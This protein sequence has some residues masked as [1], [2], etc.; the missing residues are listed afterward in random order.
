MRLLEQIFDKNVY[1]TI[2]PPINIQ[3][4]C[5]F[6]MKA[7]QPVLEQQYNTSTQKQLMSAEQDNRVFLWYAIFFKALDI[8]LAHCWVAKS[9]MT[10]TVI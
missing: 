8:R 6:D 7:Y 5:C 1:S 10:S 9:H 4:S 3:M 2:A